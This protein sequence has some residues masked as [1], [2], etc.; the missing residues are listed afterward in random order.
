MAGAGAG[1]QRSGVLFRSVVRPSVT[2]RSGLEQPMAQRQTN[3]QQASR[4]GA[5][6][7]MASATGIIEP[8]SRTCSWPQ[9]VLP[10]VAG[11]AGFE[12]SMAHKCNTC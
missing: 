8:S 3:Q 6:A 7:G 12:A 5:H 9:H 4:A 2:L 1:R 10:A 11:H